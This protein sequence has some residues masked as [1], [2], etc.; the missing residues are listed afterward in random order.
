ME[1]E[2]AR[3]AR[4]S[5][6]T[7]SGSCSIPIR[8]NG[9]EFELYDIAADPAEANNH[10]AQQPEVMARLKTQ[11]EAWVAT[12]PKEYIKTDDKED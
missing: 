12:L 10:A 3:L 5:S 2:F 7:G 9:G 1:D 4:R 6:A 8:K 11:L